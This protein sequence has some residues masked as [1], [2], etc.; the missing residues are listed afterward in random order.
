L[1]IFA[2]AKNEP[3]TA[4]TAQGNCCAPLSLATSCLFSLSVRTQFRSYV[5]YCCVQRY[6]L[7]DNFSLEKYFKIQKSSI[8]ILQSPINSVVH[9][10]KWQRLDYI[11][12]SSLEHF[13]IQSSLFDIGYSNRLQ[14]FLT[15]FSNYTAVKDSIQ[16]MIFV[17]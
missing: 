16:R 17:W 1:F 12:N 15:R 3:K 8:N 14:N 4:F 11:N 9:Y 6:D 13:E 5:L 7:I 10:S 2:C